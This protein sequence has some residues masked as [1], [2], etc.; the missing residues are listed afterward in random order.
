MKVIN[1]GDATYTENPLVEG[2]KLG[3]DARNASS[4]EKNAESNRMNAE[5]DASYK[6]EDISVR[7]N[8][9]AAELAKAQKEED[10]KNWDNG[11]KL[12][13]DASKRA[14]SFANEPMKQMWET[15]EGYKELTKVIK[16]Y[17]GP[18]FITAEGK[19]NYLG[20][21]TMVEDQLKRTEAQLTQRIQAVGYEGLTEQERNLADYFKGGDKSALAQTI[22]AIQNDPNYRDA[23]EDGDFQKAQEIV[24]KHKGMLMS[25]SRFGG[26]PQQESTQ[27][28]NDPLGILTK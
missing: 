6:K 23:I 2:L 14:D 19:I 15:S 3:L 11:Y 4:N 12:L 1:V 9:L 8:A 10:A 20:Q 25:E 5:T 28:Q 22:T 7:K 24:N 27:N 17:M 26:K 16:K 21:Q 18:E 13:T